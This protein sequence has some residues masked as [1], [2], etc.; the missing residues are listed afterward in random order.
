MGIFSS[1]RV[2]LLLVVF[3]AF[4]PMWITLIREVDQRRQEALQRI[5]SDS[6]NAAELAAVREEQAI[7]VTAQTLR[8]MARAV[9]SSTARCEVLADLAWDAMASSDRY[10]H[11]G[12]AS[13]TGRILCRVQK[14]ATPEAVSHKMWI[15]RNGA[16]GKLSIFYYR[17][18]AIHRPALLVATPLEPVPDVPRAFL[19]ASIDISRL[20]RSSLPGKWAGDPTIL[21]AL[22][23]ESGTLAARRPDQRDLADA[24]N[25]TLTDLG[26]GSKAVVRVI[27]DPSGAF[28]V[29][30]RA[31]IHGRSQNAALGVLLAVPKDHVFQDVNTTRIRG[32]LAILTVTA[33]ALIIAWIMG[34]RVLWTPLTH[35]VDA[36]D[37]IASGDLTVRSR[38]SERR[39]ELGLLARAFN[40]MA[41]ALEKREQDHLHAQE[42]IRQ[43]E[44]RLRRLGIHLQQI[45]EEEQKRLAMEIHDDIGQILTALRFDL[46]WIRN[47]TATENPEKFQGRIARMFSLLDNGMESVHRLCGQLRPRILD[48]LGLAEAIRWQAEEFAKRTGIDCDTQGVDPVDLPTEHALA[49]FR[50]LQ[51]SLTNV[52]RHAGARRV[53]VR[54]SAEIGEIRLVVRDDG[55]GIDPEACADPGAYGLMSMRERAA[56]LG[57]SF[58]AVRHP[59]GGTVAEARLPLPSTASRE[60]RTSKESST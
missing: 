18:P 39:D 7:E 38:L 21:F 4:L 33:L 26:A 50:I 35:L 3:V 51:E 31:P 57:G 30:S 9:S 44:Q 49:L 60:N 23:D 29:C 22:V 46:S 41:A 36:T 2:R 53:E 8:A 24:L 43:N 28:W 14:V 40:T 32:L 59:D 42:T 13:S 45:R 25:R 19:F 27:R 12:L 1:L 17:I 20:A 15:H 16:G 52:A 5:L 11:F 55:R 56:A 47:H 6:L 34:G 48:D 58:H 10:L 54:M 37:Q